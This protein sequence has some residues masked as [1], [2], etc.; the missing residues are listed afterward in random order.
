MLRA[1]LAFAIA[2]VPFAVAAQSYRCA[3]KDGKK[4][5]GQSIPPQCVRQPIEQLNAQGTVVKRIDAQ[6][7][8]DERAKKDSEEA[9]R[10]KREAL[11][12]EQSRRD[13]ALLATYANEKDIES[14]RS[15]VLE[16]NQRAIK[17]LEARIAALKLR[18]A[19][20]KEDVNSIDIDLRMQ[21]SLL[22]SKKKEVVAVN[23]KY[24]D[25]KK[26]YVELTKRG[27]SP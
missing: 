7:S 1:V 9:E 21:E 2:I 19:A 5:Y 3:G 25:E 22:A 26:R 6:V 15:R 11:S 24:D 18:R 20:P 16:D 13:Q 14:A 4:Y 12:K 10:K 17:E 27:K 23:A 8:A